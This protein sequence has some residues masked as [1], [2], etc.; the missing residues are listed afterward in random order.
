MDVSIK[1]WWYVEAA[2]HTTRG[3]DESSCDVLAH[4][5]FAHG[6]FNSARSAAL[7]VALGLSYYLYRGYRRVSSGTMPIPPINKTPLSKESRAEQSADRRIFAIY[8][9][10]L[11]PAESHGDGAQNTQPH[12]QKQKA[13]RAR[14]RILSPAYQRGAHHH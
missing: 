1:I 2:R 5:T 4:R 8:A 9:R 7:L 3:G 14:A 12:H 11:C 13:E 6:F 10:P